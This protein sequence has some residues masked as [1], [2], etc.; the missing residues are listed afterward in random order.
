M[1]RGSAPSYEPD[2]VEIGESFQC[3]KKVETF[4]FEM[5]INCRSGREI[6]RDYPAGMRLVEFV[7]HLEESL[8]EAPN[9]TLPIDS[10]TS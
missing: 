1:T 5:R 3:L 8:R 7:I 2:T 4:I 9:P 6:H 10:D